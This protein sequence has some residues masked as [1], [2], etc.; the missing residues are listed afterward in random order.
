MVVEN[1]DF[2]GFISWFESIGGFDIILPFL[3]MFAIVF[4]ILDKIKLF[5]DKKNIN[6]VVSIIVAFFLV[7]QQD[8]VFL[9]QQ[10]IPRVSMLILT[11]ILILLVAGTFGFGVGENWKGLS[12][13]IAIAGVLWALGA[14]LGWNVPALDY[15]T[16]QDVAV[17][18]VI[19]IFILVI[20][21]IVK[22]PPTAGQDGV[23]KKIWDFLK[24][25]GQ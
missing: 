25:F 15:F 5:G 22:E 3:L 9:I 24:G 6:A 21:F 13:I 12:V 18:L 19:G 8:M 4:A 1:I 7:V 11:L 23:G 10:F 16:D 17:L 2:V 20:W 14:S